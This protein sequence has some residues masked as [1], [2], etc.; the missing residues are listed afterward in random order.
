MYK[1]SAEAL[2]LVLNKKLKLKACVWRILHTA[3]SL[4]NESDITLSCSS[5][6]III[7]FLT[8]DQLHKLKNKPA[9]KIDIRPT[10][11]YLQML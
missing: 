6:A 1:G 7:W 5:N 11:D 4:L 2:S 3:V 8:F 10:Q 9:R